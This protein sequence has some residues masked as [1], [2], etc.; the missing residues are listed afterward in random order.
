MTKTDQ[1]PDRHRHKWHVNQARNGYRCPPDCEATEPMTPI[2]PWTNDRPGSSAPCLPCPGCGQDR[3]IR[4]IDGWG[5]EP[6][7]G[8]RRFLAGTLGTGT[9]ATRA[10]A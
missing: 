5:C 4:P 2:I 3:L 7:T 8:V 9:Q 6:C 10:A 1:Q